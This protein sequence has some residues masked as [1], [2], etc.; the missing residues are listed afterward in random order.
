MA[1]VDFRNVTKS[2]GTFTAVRSGTMAWVAKLDWPKKCEW[3]ASPSL[4][5]A[6]VPSIRRPPKQWRIAWSQ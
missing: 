5:S 4:L 1:S 3:I 2:F 6:V